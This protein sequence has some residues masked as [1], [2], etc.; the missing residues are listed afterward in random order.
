MKDRA[1]RFETM[2]VAYNCKAKFDAREFVPDEIVTS[3]SHADA[4]E[5]AVVNRDYLEDVEDARCVVVAVRRS[6]YEVVKVFNVYIDVA[7]SVD[8]EERKSGK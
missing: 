6:G 5:E 3:E 2:L 7:I 1:K 8:A 4:A